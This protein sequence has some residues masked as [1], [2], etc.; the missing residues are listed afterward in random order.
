MHQ[1]G[2]DAVQ[3]ALQIDGTPS[4]AGA[5]LAKAAYDVAIFGR[6]EFIAH[7]QNVERR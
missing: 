5:Q 3:L 1:V 4:H 6:A 2:L 7:A